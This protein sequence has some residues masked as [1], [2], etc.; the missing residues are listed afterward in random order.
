MGCIFG[1]NCANMYSR[2]IC[3]DTV[4]EQVEKFINQP[5][6]EKTVY[7]NKITAAMTDDNGKVT[8]SEGMMIIEVKNTKK[9]PKFRF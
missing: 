4:D 7:G 2:G 5:T 1:K 6:K 8:I 3:K 9:A